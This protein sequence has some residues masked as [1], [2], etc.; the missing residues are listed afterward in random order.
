MRNNDVPIQCT[1]SQG[2]SELLFV[3]KFGRLSM[4]LLKLTFFSCLQLNICCIYRLEKRIQAGMLK[5]M[6]SVS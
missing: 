5:F 4:T 6:Q 2:I 1:N 3:T